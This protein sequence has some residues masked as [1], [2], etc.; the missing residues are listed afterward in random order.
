MLSGKATISVSRNS[1]S[2]SGIAFGVQ[3]NVRFQDRATDKAAKMA[4]LIG[5]AIFSNCRLH[6]VI[7]DFFKGCAIAINNLA[8]QF[9]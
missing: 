2:G 5:A 3:A 7:Q 9:P 1:G 6:D 8:I 4:F